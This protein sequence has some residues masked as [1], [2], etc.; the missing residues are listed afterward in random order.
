MIKISLIGFVFVIGIVSCT[1]PEDTKESIPLSK[2]EALDEL[3]ES[4]QEIAVPIS[5]HKALLKASFT[6]P[7]MY[8]EFFS[9]K[10]I[11]TF[12]EKD[13]LVLIHHFDSLDFTNDFVLTDKK[14]VNNISIQLN[15]QICTHPGSGEKW[16]MT[17]KFEIN[18]IVY[19]GCAKPN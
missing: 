10:A 9:D 11:F 14:G 15:Q 8:A 1:I 18:K 12:P 7:F 3:A 6:E 16:P 5:F 19:Q 2:I 4:D 17:A 13:T